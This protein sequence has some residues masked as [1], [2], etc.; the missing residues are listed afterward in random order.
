[1]HS[2]TIALKTNPEEISIYLDQEIQRSA[3]IDRINN[4]LNLTGIIPGIYTLSISKDGFSSWSK[5]IEVHSGL[6]T[7]FWNIL[8]GKNNYEKTVYDTGEIKKFFVSP[9]NKYVLNER[10]NSDGVSVTIFNPKSQ[11][12]KN[13]FFFPQWNILEKS[14]KEN[15]EWS[16]EEDQLSVPLQ[17]LSSISSENP[18]LEY[19][20]F[21]INPENNSSFNLN[22]F[23]GGKS[24]RNVRW[25][26][27]EK[28]YLFFLEGASLYRA[29]ITDKDDLTL[30]SKDASSFELSESYVYYSEFPNELVYK[31]SLSTNTDRIQITNTFPEIPADH[32]ERL[33]VYDDDRIAFL[34][35]KKNLFVYNKG[36]KNTYFKK[37]SSRAEGMQF[38]NDGKKLL[39]W[40]ANEI[41]VY[42]LRDWETQP[43]KSED[44][45]LDITRYS[46]PIK[47][48][49]WFKDYEH[50]IF[51]AGHQ[52]K[53][54]ELDY[55]DKKNYIEI[56][57][58]SIM[59]PFVVYNFTLERMFFTDQAESEENVL[60][61][62]SID[63][64][65]RSTLLGI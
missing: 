59:D 24:I 41:Y 40:N 25:D 50:I 62:Y 14:H 54:V 48:V 53:A 9:K 42:Y 52:I 34:D 3:K 19:A 4:S 47:N 22:E 46:D 35:A 43:A 10:E 17:K 39:H 2:G 23:L 57:K 56:K 65:E 31:T 33:I 7:E 16:P 38:S 64:P 20:Y 15:V 26:P 28:E 44:E 30:I 5:K 1:M 63:F 49:Q 8:L 60:N 29:N 32:T 61:L 11:L 45:S 58:T 12:A 18:Q 13:V 6:A 36:I 27:K 37:L 51:S 55:R 21:V